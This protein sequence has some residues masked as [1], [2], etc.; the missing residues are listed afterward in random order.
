M[1]DFM[2]KIRVKFAVQKGSIARAK[3]YKAVKGK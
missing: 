3:I 1:A 2:R